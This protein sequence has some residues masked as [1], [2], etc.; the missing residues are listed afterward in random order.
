MTGKEGQQKSLCVSQRSSIRYEAK[1]LAATKESFLLLDLFFAAMIF[2]A[3]IASSS[4]Y[5]YLTFFSSSVF[6]KLFRLLSLFFSF[7]A[8]LFLARLKS[9]AKLPKTRR[10][11]AVPSCSGFPVIIKKNRDTSLFPHYFGMRA[12]VNLFTFPVSISAFL[13]TY[14]FFPGITDDGVVNWKEK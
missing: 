1:R 4:S 5:A 6:T 14:A 11:T 3:C 9:E 2:L 8:P 10:L 7:S 13:F 12:K